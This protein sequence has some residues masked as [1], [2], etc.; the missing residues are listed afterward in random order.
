MS[1]KWCDVATR[2]LGQGDEIQNCYDGIIN[3][4]SGHLIISDRKVMFLHE[5]GFISKTYLL[6]FDIS[7]EN[8]LKVSQEGPYEFSIS[9]I[10]GNTFL[11][12]AYEFPAEL[13]LQSLESSEESPITA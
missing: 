12:K 13:I 2:L 5:T 11:I 7:R 1:R 9:D 10:F 6:I 4:K 8:I 3:C